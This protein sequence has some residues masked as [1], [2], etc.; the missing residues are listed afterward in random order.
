MTRTAAALPLACVCS[1]AV[2]WAGEAELHRHYKIDSARSRAT[3]EVGK[4]GPLSFAA[5]HSHE[6][7]A[8]GIA[9]D[10]AVDPEHVDRS[11]VKIAIDARRLK[12]ADRHEPPDDVPKVQETMEGAQV[13]DVARY[14][15]I[16]FESTQIEVK[17]HSADTLDLIVTGRLALHGATRIVSAPVSVRADEG[18]IVAT[19]RFPVKQTDF[20]IKPVTVG[21]VVSVKDAV[22]IS[23]T[24][25]G[26]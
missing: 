17:R 18:G 15:T 14:P 20:S 10:I 22:T 6:V 2:T 11:T 24:I 7:D 19:G 8:D 23:F 25:A 26:R 12:V 4:S 13:L 21:G 3:I 5:G 16:A 9:G 1:L